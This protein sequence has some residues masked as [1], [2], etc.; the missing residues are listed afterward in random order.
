M[1]KAKGKGK[2]TV[3]ELE[4]LEDE[5]EDLDDDEEEEDVEDEEDE[6][7]DEDSEGDDEEDED[8]DDEDEDED[9]DEEEAPK[10]SK[11][12]AKSKARKPR[13][14]GKCGTFELAEALETDGRNL[15]VMLRDRK[16]KKNA[17]NNRYEWDS[18]AA[19]L[20]AMKFK[21]VAAAKAALKESRQ[22]RLDELKERVAATRK[23]KGGKKKSKGKKK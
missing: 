6:D 1:A 18:V 17:E 9:E 22:Q 10:K 8:S 20:K 16:V 4:E 11:K 15:R 5:L 12:G 13:E 19:A 21:N 23:D 7:E 14:D 3:D 2:K